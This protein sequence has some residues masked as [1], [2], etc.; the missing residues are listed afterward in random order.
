[1]TVAD[2][3]PLRGLAAVFDA[4]RE[5]VIIRDGAGKVVGWNR[6]AE[7]LYGWSA[8]DILGCDA[9]DMLHSRPRQ[10]VH[11]AVWSGEISR[12]TANRAVVLVDARITPEHAEDGALLYTIETGRDVTEE[13]PARIALEQSEYR[14]RNLFQAMT[15]A[16][17]EVDVSGATPILTDIWASGVTDLEAYF[18]ARPDKV[19]ELMHAT[20]VIDVNEH[21]VSQFGEG[22]RNV[23]IRDVELFW[24]EES[25]PQYVQVL[26]ARLR[27]ETH[28]TTEA[29]V[30]TVSGRLV[31][32]VFTACLGPELTDQGR[33]IFGAIDISGLKETSAALAKSRERFRNLFQKTP[34][35][36]CQL[37]A[38]GLAAKYREWSAVLPV[39][40][41]TFFEQY[42]ER[43]DEVMDTLI[44]DEANTLAI[45]LLG[46]DSEAQLIGMPV[47]RFWAKRR[48]TFQRVVTARLMG[49][50]SYQEE[51]QMVA[52]DGGVIDIVFAC[53]F[54]HGEGG[55][56]IT[57]IGMADIGDRVK[58]QQMLS[59]LQ[60]D[61]AH[62]ARISMLGELTA[63]LAHEVSQPLMAIAANADAGL[64]WLNR[65]EPEV[66]EAR[67]LTERIVG[68]ARR[69]SGIISRIRGMAGRRLPEPA[70]ID[71]NTIV[72]GTA[73][74]L[75][76]QAQ[77]S[78]VHVSLKLEADLPVVLGDR[79]QLEQVVANLAIN[80]M[81][82]LV[83]SG[84][85]HRAV[86]L[87]TRRRGLAGV[88]CVIDDNGPGIAEDDLDRL[89]DSFFTTKPT[90]M[91][92]GL[93]I[94][95]SII[96]SHGGQLRA[97]NREHGKGA[98]FTFT[99][100]AMPET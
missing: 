52:L 39:T 62:A 44:I 63:S 72:E 25:Y 3:L 24:P 50:T 40:P 5:A 99:L 35:A 58:A 79:T 6:A 18:A 91:G 41:G 49:Q 59:Q 64:R 26:L 15:A 33:I 67:E 77:S 28:Y 65:P 56:D 46:A 92:L 54:Q 9:D 85:T 55:R 89:F 80:A 8:A 19:R 13:R 82:A 1:M 87:T 12:T 27:G 38:S 96:Q 88:V 95:R 61:F 20:F 22:D 53:S 14:Y 57:L 37:D 98:R 34:I 66:A 60:S 93:P 11:A 2:P 17:W 94:C 31:D 71:L 84:Q 30:R 47:R 16:F 74:F 32:V 90:G 68:D 76:S 100:P 21:T 51:T 43:L 7:T 83:Q 97:E 48:D 45:K 70:P 29:R 42:P 73:R 86:T 4:V 69:A 81:Q 36:L 23:L 10:A 75:E 78:N